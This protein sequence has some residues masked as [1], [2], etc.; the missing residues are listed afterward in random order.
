MRHFV[1]SLII[2]FFLLADSSFA[3][4]G[5]SYSFSVLNIAPTARMAALGNS[6]NATTG[7]DVGMAFYNPA[8]SVDS[9]HQHIMLSYQNYLADINIGY[10]GYAWKLRKYGT[11]SGHILYNDFG[12][13]VKTDITGKSYGTFHPSDLIFQI[14]YGQVH[15]KD[16]RF[17]VGGSIKF[18]YSNYERYIATV[19]AIDAGAAFHNPEKLFNA[20]VLIRNAGWNAIPYDNVR[21]PLPF[22]IQLGL[23]KKLA[24][25]P[26]RFT[27]VAHNLQQFDITY[28]NTNLRNKNIDLSTGQVQY[29]KASFGEKMMRHFNFG[30]ELVF[31]PN[32][33][34]RG[35]YNY[36]R[37]KE[38]S[39]ES[40]KGSAG[41]SWGLGI[42]IKKF[43]LDYAM[44][45][46]FPGLWTSTFTVS[47]NIQDF[48]RIKPV[49]M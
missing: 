2:S 13:F 30:A 49:N 46:Y 11:L 3:Q 4:L 29:E 38:L 18:L 19:F 8:L 35:G 45:C 21:S 39:P 41:F 5:G 34:L 32:F 42:G 6:T 12:T 16:D 40:G 48:K 14:S 27:M 47:K 28:V 33:Q 44:V 25:N 31:S 1:I 17:T 23:S 26:L 9:M 37:R 36:Q 20:A 7:T 22:D 10:V 15:P 43:T 24:H